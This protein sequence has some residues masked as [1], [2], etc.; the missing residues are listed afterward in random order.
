MFT[1]NY[2]ESTMNKTMYC[3]CNVMNALNKVI[4]ILKSSMQQYVGGRM[5]DFE[6]KELETLLYEDSYQVKK[7]WQTL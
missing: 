1:D 3:K 2:C 5:K 4:F 7:N 6:D